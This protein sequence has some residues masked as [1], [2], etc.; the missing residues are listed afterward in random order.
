MI[1]AF[2]A[3][4]GTAVLWQLDGCRARAVARAHDR[5]W[6][7]TA[8]AWEPQLDAPAARMRDSAMAALQ[9]LADRHV[10]DPATRVRLGRHLAQRLADTAADTRTLAV[11]AALDVTEPDPAAMQALRVAAAELLAANPPTP[12]R[13][14]ALEVL[15]RLGAAPAD[16]AVVARIARAD[17]DPDV[18]A[19]A[20]TVV[21]R[22]GA[23]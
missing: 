21:H 11:T 4:V 5:V 15:A 6:G 20:A 1:V 19:L 23:P 3:A 16:S 12:S 2:A 14:A 22:A 13:V 17:P 8:A 18:R 9:E 10:L 7:R